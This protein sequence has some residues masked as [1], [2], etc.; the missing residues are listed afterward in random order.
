MN[1][2]SKDIATNQPMECINCHKRT[3]RIE[4]EYR[5]F[6][7]GFCAYCGGFLE[8]VPTT[9]SSTDSP[10]TYSTGSNPE[11]TELDHDQFIR[12]EVLAPLVSDMLI[13]HQE[14]A[15]SRIKSDTSGRYTEAINMLLQWHTTLTEQAVLEALNRL[16]G[17][18]SISDFCEADKERCSLWVKNGKWA[19]VAPEGKNL[20]NG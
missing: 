13:K 6:N 4:A 1:N 3:T 17:F 10:E 11:G 7:T 12:F 19:L 2:P 20:S 16:E 8:H 14:E 5:N 9:Q 18:I 15:G